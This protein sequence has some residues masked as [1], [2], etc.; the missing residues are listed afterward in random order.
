MT[1]PTPL[2]DTDLQRLA[3]TSLRVIL[4]LQHSGGAY[5]ASPDFSA[6][7][8]YSWFRDGSF[9]ADAASAAGAVDSAERFHDWCAEIIRER[10]ARIDEIVRRADSGDPVPD[11]DMLATRFTFDG[12]EG[13]DEWWDFQLDGYGTW[14]WALGAHA[15]RHGAGT[16][17]WS[18]AIEL[19]A[20]YIASSWRRPCFD[21]W[22]EHRDQVH[23]STLGCIAAGLRAALALGTLSPSTA[24]AARTAER[25]IS[26]I[27]ET[28]AVAD[29]HLSKWIG[30]SAV[31]GSL[32]ALVG[33]LG[34]VDAAS[35]IGADTI[36]ALEHDLVRDAGSF[37]YLGDTFFGGGQWP[38][39]SC[40]LGQ[41][42][43]AAGDPTRARELLL[44]AA[45]TADAEGMMPEQ[46]D[47][48]VND[49][50]FIDVWIDR[51]GPVARPLVWS[52]A[53]FLRLA[54]DLG[55]V[56]PTDLAEAAR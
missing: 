54:L 51:W 40:M 46:V 45:S 43:L 36:T 29:G 35:R 56:R 12:R 6:Y 42:H 37:R 39:L 4:T 21:W 5:P 2:T 55:L 17:Q 3:V 13:T 23:V 20:A 7:V 19:C 31:D 22:E 11:Q 27:L 52:H 26:T 47:R 50:S 44:W 8:G 9:I 1:T 38:L 15:D 53:M 24:H 48:H 14:L 18:D 28:G 33:V 30:S 32:G 25:E 34:V 49:A 41:A 10:A 16:A